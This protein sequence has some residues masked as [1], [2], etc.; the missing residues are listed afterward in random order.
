VLDGYSRTRLA[1]AT[2]PS[3]A[4]WVALMVL[5]TTTTPA[6]FAQAH[7]AFM[8]LYNTTAHHG[9]LTEPSA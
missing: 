2:A 5:S 9:L 7:Q 3:E 6:E 1:G 8:H 4:S